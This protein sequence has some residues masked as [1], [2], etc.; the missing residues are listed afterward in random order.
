VILFPLFGLGITVTTYQAMYL[1]TTL[2]LLLAGG[3]IWGLV[4]WRQR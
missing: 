3:A 4:Q 1:V 2:L